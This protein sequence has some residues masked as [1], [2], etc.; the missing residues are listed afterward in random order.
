MLSNIGAFRM[1][2]WCRLF[3]WK[4]EYLILCGFRR[5]S[6][7]LSKC[8]RHKCMTHYCSSSKILQFGKHVRR[9]QIMQ[10]KIIKSNP[11]V[12]LLIWNRCMYSVSKTSDFKPQ[13]NRIDENID[14][15]A[16]NSNE[17]YFVDFIWAKSLLFCY[18]SCPIENLCDK[19]THDIFSG[20]L[21]MHKPRT[22]CF[23]IGIEIAH[24]EKIQ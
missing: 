8:S 20:F 10:S 22:T 18:S 5:F 6:N 13:T 11:N 14:S 7:V 9:I 2:N 3:G 24:D 12:M 15:F 23:R 4:M 1:S 21:I 17:I 19:F 16:R